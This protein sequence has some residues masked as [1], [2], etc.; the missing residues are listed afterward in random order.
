MET[1]DE[2]FALLKNSN[3]IFI[4]HFY[5]L[6]RILDILLGLKKDCKKSY[7]YYELIKQK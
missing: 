2:R 7:L 4:T 1:S 5:Y 6:L 3:A